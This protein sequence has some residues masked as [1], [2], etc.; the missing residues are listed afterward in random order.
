MQWRYATNYAKTTLN[1][2]ETKT[3]FVGWAFCYKWPVMQ[4]NRA[5]FRDS[6]GRNMPQLACEASPGRE[7]G[8]WGERNMR[9]GGRACHRPPLTNEISEL[10]W[11]KNSHWLRA[12][13]CQST[14]QLN[15]LRGDYLLENGGRRLFREVLPSRIDVEVEYLWQPST[16]SSSGPW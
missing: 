6:F 14:L 2:E 3:S 1:S 10:V 11:T 12:T 7:E 8:D 16:C 4:N 13:R 9:R 5:V 15:S